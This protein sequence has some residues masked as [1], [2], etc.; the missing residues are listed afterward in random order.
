MGF[1][2]FSNSDP[3]LSV[4]CEASR[5]AFSNIL[6]SVVSR[7]LSNW[8]SGFLDKLTSEYSSWTVRG[9]KLISSVFWL[10]S[11]FLLGITRTLYLYWGSDLPGSNNAGELILRGSKLPISLFFNSS[12]SLCLLFCFCFCFGNNSSLIGTIL[13]V[14]LSLSSS[15]DCKV[16]VSALAGTLD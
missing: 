10:N 6:L 9:L 8:I 14:A 15:T 2:C 16:V 1:W 11:E 12:S 3:R 13:N 4:L 7:V 5:E